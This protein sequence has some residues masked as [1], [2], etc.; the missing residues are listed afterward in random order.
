MSGMKPDP[1]GWYS[2]LCPWIGL[3]LLPDSTM[4]SQHDAVAPAHLP[5]LSAAA[6]SLGSE[7]NFLGRSL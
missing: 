4:T 7:T 5:Y 6:G 2:S 3:A 1:L